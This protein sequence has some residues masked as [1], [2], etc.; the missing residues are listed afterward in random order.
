MPDTAANQ[1]YRGAITNGNTV[2]VTGRGD[3]LVKV[4]GNTWGSGTVALLDNL[5]GTFK[6]TDVAGTA[7]TVNSGG[8]TWLFERPPQFEHSQRLSLSGAT[9]EDVEVFV[10]FEYPPAA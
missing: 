4:F 2:T 3:C 9:G 10:T 5:T 6:A 8:R 7:A 1:T